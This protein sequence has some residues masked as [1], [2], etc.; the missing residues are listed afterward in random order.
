MLLLGRIDDAE[1]VIELVAD[2]AVEHDWPG[3]LAA[4]LI[5]QTEMCRM[6]GDLTTAHE[7]VGPALALAAQ[8][9]DPVLE[10]RA[11]FERGWLFMRQGGFEEASKHFALGFDLLIEGGELAR[12]GDCQMGLANVMQQQGLVDEA[13]K[14][15]E[16]THS[17]YLEGGS[18][19]GLIRLFVARGEIARHRGQLDVAEVLYREALQRSEAV[20]YGGLIWPLINLGITLLA[21]RR[22]NEAL[23]PLQRCLEAAT[24]QGRRAVM[25]YANLML[26]TCAAAQRRW[27]AYDGHLEEGK[28]FSAETGAVELDVATCVEQAAEYALEAG[29][30]ERAREAFEIA[31]QQ[32]E[33]LRRADDVKRVTQQI[34]QLTSSE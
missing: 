13:A 15:F 8:V 29:E 34:E 16:R 5:R 2:L 11:H 4:A 18:R 10:G 19:R 12:A 28:R 7:V 26:A 33:G 3:P 6:R 23:E 27:E 22:P 25:G 31:L 30:G 24:R 14:G 32:W 17:Q 20:G 9:G 1:P 21:A